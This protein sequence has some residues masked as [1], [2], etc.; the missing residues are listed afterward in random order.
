[1]KMEPNQKKLNSRHK[2]SYSSNKEGR[3]FLAVF[4]FC[5]LLYTIFAHVCIGISFILTLWAIIY[6]YNLRKNGQ[7]VIKMRKKRIL[8][9]INEIVEALSL[10]NKTRQLSDAAL[11][12]LMNIKNIHSCWIQL[13]LPEKNKLKLTAYRNF[14]KK[15]TGELNLLNSMNGIDSYVFGLGN[16]VSI[17]NLPN[18]TRFGLSSFK[19]A[20]LFSVAVV[21]LRTYHTRGILGVASRVR[22][23]F[24]KDFIDVLLL[25][26]N[27][28]C[29]ALDKADLYQRLEDRVSE[30]EQE[31][32]YE[33]KV[34]GKEV[35]AD[36]EYEETTSDQE[37]T[38]SIKGLEDLADLAEEYHRRAHSAIKDAIVEA[39]E[40]EK[41]P[42]QLNRSSAKKID[43]SEG[44]IENQNHGTEDAVG[45]TIRHPESYP[46]KGTTPYSLPRSKEQ[47]KVLV[48]KDESSRPAKTFYIH[49]QRMN[50]FRKFH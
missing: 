41:I 18:D 4:F 27:L 8:S 43:S 38:I 25:I 15:M 12:S 5:A 17:S 36:R 35:N 1:M 50:K 11:D 40:M 14:S 23:Y 32:K 49:T 2:I 21:P 26:G 10:S 47:A 22:D 13:L 20:G 19:E 31:I 33:A 39:K 3:I 29:A 44:G 7:R 46:T 37:T 42:T 30:L 16:N 45:G 34:N 28:V 9:I 48:L 24:D 6:N